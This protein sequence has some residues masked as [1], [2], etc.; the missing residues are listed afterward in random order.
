V[1]RVLVRLDQAGGG[2]RRLRPWHGLPTQGEGRQTDIDYESGFKDVGR[3]LTR[4][5]SCLNER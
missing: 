4:Q 2:R 3:V 5:H 1:N